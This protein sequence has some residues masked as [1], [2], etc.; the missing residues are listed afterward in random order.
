MLN[1][2]LIIAG[3]VCWAAMGAWPAFG[4]VVGTVHK[5]PVAPTNGKPAKVVAG[6]NHLT[7]KALTVRL[8]DDRRLD[9]S[10]IRVTAYRSRVGLYGSVPNYHQK[11]IAEQIAQQF[12]GITYVADHLRVATQPLPDA[13]LAERIRKAL[14]KN[15][16]TSKAAIAVEAHR[17]V[18]GLRGTVK[19][20]YVKWTA[21]HLAKRVPRVSVVQDNLHVRPGPTGA[22]LASAVKSALR[23]DK[24][25]RNRKFTVLSHSSGH[26]DLRGVVYS[27]TAKRNAGNVASKVAGVTGISNAITVLKPALKRYRHP[28][29]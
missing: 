15:S 7:E 10:K 27:K 9:G 14:K 21:I 28:T 1:R 12:S 24:S 2:S 16:N 25:L 5:R 4:Q 18:V 11:R 6:P 8:R 17:G 20:L 19:T 29:R 13:Q 22:A 26:I 3:A 23:A